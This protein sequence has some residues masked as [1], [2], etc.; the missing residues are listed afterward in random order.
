MKIRIKTTIILSLLLVFIACRNDN[1]ENNFIRTNSHQFILQGKPYYFVGTNYWYGPILASTGRGG[2]RDRLIK[3]L[4]LMKECGIKNLR[5]LAGAEGPDNEPYR[6]TPALQTAPGIY[7]DTLLD[8]LDFLMN[9]MAKREMHAVIYLNNTWEWSGGYA[10]YLNWNGYG[11]IPYPNVEPYSWP[12]FMDYASKFHSCQ[13][14]RKQYRE[15]IKYVIERKNRY[16]GKKYKDDPNIMTWEIAN[17]PRALKE[18][19]KNRF[20]QWVHETATYIKSLDPGH[21]VTTGTEGKHGCEQDMELFKSIHSD[22]NIDYLTMHIWPK[23]WGWLDCENIPGTIDTSIM[24]AETYMNEH[25]KVSRDLKKPIVFEEFGLPR[26]NHTFNT[27]DTTTAR[28]K[29]YQYAFSI[30]ELHAKTRDVLAGTNFWAF[31]GYGRHS[32]TYT[33]WKPGDILMGDPPQEEQGLNSV[34]DTDHTM[35][36]IKKHAYNLNSILSK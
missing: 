26:D 10:Q 8:G 9:E 28:D 13:P 19:N 6:V 21:L 3:E 27:N 15:F 17:E 34:F 4:N 14:C 33:Y 22:P 12:E 16:T 2:D 31:T 24:L 5:I 20:A 23:N 25:I 1:K 18:E 29:Y 35:L 36:L 11:P 7:N 32:K 30:V